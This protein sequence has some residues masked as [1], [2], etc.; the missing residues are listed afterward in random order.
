MVTTILIVEDDGVLRALLSLFL[1]ADDTDLVAVDGL[2]AGL[3]ELRARAFDLVISDVHLGDGSGLEV[4]RATRAR[5]GAHVVVVLM[6]GD[7]VGLRVAQGAGA[8]DFVLK[9]FFAPDLVERCAA[10]MDRTG[11]PLARN[12]LC[13]RARRVA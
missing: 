9:P 4:A 13:L 8:D 6:S 3:A 11:K 5:L 1:A 12:E 10:L 7:D 2:Q